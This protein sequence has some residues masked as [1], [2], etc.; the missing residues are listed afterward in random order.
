MVSHRNEGREHPLLTHAVSR[1]RLLA[2]IPGGLLIAAGLAACGGDDD[3][4]PTG[5]TAAGSSA[6][7]PST[8]VTDATPTESIA[9]PATGSAELRLI[10]LPPSELGAPEVPE[11][12]VST[13]D[14][15]VPV[16]DAIAVYDP[17]GTDAE[18]GVFP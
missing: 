11:P 12:A 1:R 10:P 6:T 13:A 7:E 16:A 3:D 4:S 5:T 17:F 14:D 8:A 15:A 9:S 18:P 2:A